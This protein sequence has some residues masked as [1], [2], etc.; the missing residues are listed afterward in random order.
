M[1]DRRKA[2]SEYRWTSR[3]SI[4]GQGQDRP[5]AS[6]NTGSPGFGDPGDGDW[7]V[8]LCSGVPSTSKA[9][10]FPITPHCQQLSEG[11]DLGFHPKE[12]VQKRAP[13]FEQG[14]CVSPSSQ[15]NRDQGRMK[16]ATD[17]LGEVPGR[18]GVSGRTG[19]CWGVIPPPHKSEP[20]GERRGGRMEVSQAAGHLSSVQQGPW[21]VLESVTHQ[22]STKSP[23]HPLVSCISIL[24]WKQLLEAQPRP[25]EVM[26]FRVSS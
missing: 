6:L 9:S 17:L 21:G 15:R 14:E 1:N 8:G 2:D 7:G 12:R 4:H 24:T 3:S 18:E 13:I 26:D 25:K 16:H 20:R 22:R 23:R 19:R 5:A 11:G 10:L